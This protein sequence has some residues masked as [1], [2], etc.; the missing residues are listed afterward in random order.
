MVTVRT[1]AKRI[2][3]KH[4]YC[5]QVLCNFVGQLFRIGFNQGSCKSSLTLNPYLFPFFSFSEKIITGCLNQRHLLLTL[6]FKVLTSIAR[7]FNIS[8][9]STCHFC[10]LRYNKPINILFSLY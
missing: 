1:H 3:C 9:V 7:N 2:F 5:G 10:G 6:Y 4:N 8:R